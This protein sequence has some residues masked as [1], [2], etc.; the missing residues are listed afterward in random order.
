MANWS[1][2]F[3]A[4]LKSTPVFSDDGS[5]AC[6]IQEKFFNEYPFIMLSG[7]LPC[8]KVLWHHSV[9]LWNL[10]AVTSHRGAPRREGFLW[11]VAINPGLRETILTC[12]V[13]I[14]TRLSCR[15]DTNPAILSRGRQAQSLPPGG[16]GGGGGGWWYGGERV[17]PGGGGW[18]PKPRP[19]PYSQYPPG[20]V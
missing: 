4:R 3:K 16:G 19:R 2:E 17:C 13:A 1:Q 8:Y 12:E 6:I 18:A 10:E 15:V 7:F 11:S 9:L 5:H 20:W 14:N